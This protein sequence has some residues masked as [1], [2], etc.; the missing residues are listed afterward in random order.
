[1]P[2]QLWIAY[3]YTPTRE[4]KNTS[5]LFKP[6]LSEFP[7]LCSRIEFWLI[8]L[9][10][11][12]KGKK[13]TTKILHPSLSPPLLLNCALEGLDAQLP[14][15][16]N[17]GNQNLTCSFVVRIKWDNVPE[18]RRRVT[19]KGPRNW[20]LLLFQSRI[21]QSE[22]THPD[23]RILSRVPAPCFSINPV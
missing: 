5:F 8:D 22:M 20:Q 15:L 6:L 11:Y 23:S 3:H 17:T 7:D 2:Y 4:K 16:G 1:M 13:T 19:Q 10:T 21:S 18:A 12:W 14:L 9:F